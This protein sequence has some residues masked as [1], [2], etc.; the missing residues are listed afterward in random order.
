LIQK[1][2]VWGIIALVAAMLACAREAPAATPWNPSDLDIIKTPC[3]AGVDFSGGCL[4]TPTPTIPWFLPPTRSLEQP[5]LTPTPDAPRVVPTLRQD[6]DEYIVQ[7]GDTLVIIANRYS[8]SYEEIAKLNDII[9]PNSVGVGQYLLIPAPTPSGAAPSF[10]IIPDSELFYGPMSTTLD[11]PSFIDEQGGILSGY[12]EEVDGVQ[13]SGA[14][15]VQK[16]SEDFSVNPRLLIAVLEYTGGWV[17]SKSVEGGYEKYPIGYFDDNRSGLYKQLAFAANN[18]NRGFYLW[19]INAVPAWL[20]ADGSI[21]PVNGS[22]NAGTAGVQQLMS[23]L[24]SKDDWNNAVSESGVFQTYNELF[25]YPF[26]YTIENLIP[27]DLKQPEMQLPFE[28][29][30]V[31]SFTGGPH[32]GYG[33]G[34]AWAAIDFAPPG[35]LP[36]CVDNDSWITAAASG[37]VIK[38]ENGIVLTDLDGDGFPQ[39]GW[40]VL[41]LHVSTKDRIKSGE[42]VKAG[43]RIGHPSCEGGVSTGTHLHIARRYNGMWISADGNIP[44]NLDGWVSKGSGNIYDGYLVKDGL[45]IEAW[46]GKREE[47]QIQR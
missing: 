6:P 18:L 35:E 16:I 11:L 7:S 34:S 19:Q 43:D 9:D 40:S 17:R 45:S 10:K 39:T 25:G 23:T 8:V 13:M 20:L 33:E 38:S 47:N 32:G 26:D 14:E 36:G 24:Y 2:L 29:G 15:I 12:F 44:F 46:S 5:I 3:P 28:P 31:W 27:A 30:V 37:L 1:K 42:Y 21:I 41:Y 4:T 22:I